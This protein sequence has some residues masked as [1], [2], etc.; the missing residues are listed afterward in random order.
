MKLNRAG[1][2][3]NQN[4]QPYSTAHPPEARETSPNS[5]E[6]AKAEKGEGF[7]IHP[8]SPCPSACPVPTHTNPG[9]KP[10]MTSPLVHRPVLAHSCF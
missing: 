4:P 10:E 7:T 6:M 5:K 2:C 1:R 3:P 9:S 8:K